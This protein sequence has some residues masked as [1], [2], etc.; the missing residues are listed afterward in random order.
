MPQDY[1][2]NDILEEIR[3]K[4][5][6]N[7]ELPLP[8]NIWKINLISQIPCR[9]HNPFRGF[10]SHLPFLRHSVKHK[11]YRRNRHSGQLRNI[12]HNCHASPLSVSKI[13]RPL[14]HTP[15][16]MSIGLLKHLKYF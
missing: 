13:L 16:S 3:R 11:A 10:R 6:R 5:Q 12:L 4:K 2:V 15:F 1:D 14:S 8:L 9:A 7:T